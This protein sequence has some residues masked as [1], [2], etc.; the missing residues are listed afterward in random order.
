MEYLSMQDGVE[1]SP[2]AGKYAGKYDTLRLLILFL[3]VELS[4]R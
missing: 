2:A 4:S 1:L 3:T